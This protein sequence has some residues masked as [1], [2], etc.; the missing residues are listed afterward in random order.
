[1]SFIAYITSPT[2]PLTLFE[3]SKDVNLELL[4]AVNEESFPP[5][6]PSLVLPIKLTL[7]S[8]NESSFSPEEVNIFTIPS[9]ACI[10]SILPSESSTTS[11]GSSN[12]LFTPLISLSI[13][14]ELSKSINI[15]AG[16]S[17]VP[18]PGGIGFE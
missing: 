5:Q 4:S 14:S 11:L 12:E 16:I 10:I 7:P 18:D 9:L 8:A 17:P 15:F 2:Y 1:M 6:L 13:L 3:T